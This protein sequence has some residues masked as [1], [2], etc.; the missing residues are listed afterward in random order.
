MGEPLKVSAQAINI[1]KNHEG[2]RLKAYTD[3]AGVKTIGYGH[4]GTING[5]KI[6]DGM[7]IT[8]KQAEEQ[9][10]KDLIHFENTV[11]NSVKQ[12]LTQNQFDALVSFSYNVGGDA[13]QKSTLL[14]KLNSGDT[15]GAA[16]EFVRW[17]KAGGKELKGLVNRRNTEREMFLGVGQ[18]E[19]PNI[20]VPTEYDEPYDPPVKNQS[21]PMSSDIYS[22]FAPPNQQTAKSDSDSLYA[23]FSPEQTEEQ[24]TESTNPFS[25][26]F[27]QLNGTIDPLSQEPEQTTP[28]YREKYQDKLAAAFGVTPKTD[29]GMPDYIGELVKSIYDQA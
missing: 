26:Y 19:A 12:P 24:N 25:N 29:N 2:L 3:A 6:H 4:T 18:G 17:N 28:N 20:P 14:K 22:A 15:S 7:V 5:V 11:R 9:L 21:Y 8:Q 23:A 13:F 16:D 27:N 10:R 1:L